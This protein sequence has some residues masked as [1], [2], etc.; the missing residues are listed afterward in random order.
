MSAV[1]SEARGR[2]HCGARALRR[3]DFRRAS[4][5]TAIAKAAAARTGPRSSRG[6]AFRRGQVRRSRTAP[7]TSPRTNRRR[8]TQRSLLPRLRH[9]AVLRIDALARR[10]ARHRSR[11]STSPLDRAPTVHAFYAEHVAW[12]PPLADAP[13]RDAPARGD[14]RRRARRRP[15]PAHGRRRQ[16]PG[17]ARRRGRWSRTCSTRLAP[18]VGALVINANQNVERYAAFGHPVVAR[19]GRRLRGPARRPARRACA[20]RP[21][22]LVVTAPCDSPFLPRRPRRAARARGRGAATRRSRS[23][24]RST[25]RIPCSRSCA[26]RCCRISP[27]SS[28]AAAARST[29]GTRRCAVVEVAFDD[30]ADAFRNINTAAELAAAASAV[31]MNSRALR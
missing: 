21:R 3:D 7:S 10:D 25:S 13:R 19:R 31:A 2:C 15:G 23:R 30:E 1:V 9:Q 24:A 28:P 29:R 26:V 12:L 20:R 22:R 6:P 16:G 27:H 5:R 17:R 18:Q 11:R 4:S 14:H 8:G